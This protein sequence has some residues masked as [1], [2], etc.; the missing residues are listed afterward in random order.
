MYLGWKTKIGFVDEKMDPN[1]VDFLTKGHHALSHR[2][3]CL[4]TRSKPDLDTPV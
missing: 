3:T 4:R 1:T 2:L